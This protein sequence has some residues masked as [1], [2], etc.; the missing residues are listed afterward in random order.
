MTGAGTATVD[1]ATELREVA[2]ESLLRTRLELGEAQLVIGDLEALRDELA[3][4][5]AGKPKSF[6]FSFKPPAKTFQLRM[7]FK[8]GRVDKS[9]IIE[10]LEGILK[11]LKGAR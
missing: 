9:E 8:K 6:V 11:E 5:K 7:S 10:A 4:P 3:R 1:A 2:R